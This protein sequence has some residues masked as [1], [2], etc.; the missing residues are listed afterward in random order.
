MPFRRPFPPQQILQRDRR[1][2]DDQRV[3]PPLNNYVD[4][5]Q[6][7]ISEEQEEINQ[8]GG[9]SMINYLT[10]EEYENQLMI[11]QIS[12]IESEILINNEENQ[13]PDLGRKLELRSRQVPITT[14]RK[15]NVGRKAINQPVVSVMEPILVPNQPR[16]RK[17]TIK[18]REVPT[19]SFNFESE[20]SKIKVP[21]PLLELLK[22]SSYKDSFLKIL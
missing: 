3:P 1:N 16:P 21:I 6:Q 20:L 11:H 7:N 18:S 10:Q 22:I 19:S 9:P 4:E 13:Q 14:L 17:P 8:V 5:N 15:Q 2:L 12:D